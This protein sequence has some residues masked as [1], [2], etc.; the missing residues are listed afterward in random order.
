MCLPS[1]IIPYHIV[2]VMGGKGW[3]GMGG[4]GGDGEGGRG[5]RGKSTDIGE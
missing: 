4:K 3:V 5:E 1:T 2:V